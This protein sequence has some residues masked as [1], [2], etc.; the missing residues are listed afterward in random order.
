MKE[1]FTPKI[2]ILWATLTILCLLYSLMILL[3]NS[4]TF[5]FTIWLILAL[6]FY[7]CFFLSK[8]KRYKK[9]PKRIRQPFII[10]ITIGIIIFLTCQVLI[11]SHFNDNGIKDLDYIIVLG[12][13]MRD[14]GPSVIYKYRLDAAY[15]Y[16]KDN[17]DT[18]CILTGA[19]A[20]NEPVSEGEGGKEYLISKNIPKDRLIAESDSKDTV[21]NVKNAL[22]IIDKTSNTKD[23]KIG[24]VTSNFHVFRGIKI[25]QKATGHE[26]HGISAYVTPRFLPNNMVRESIGIIRDFLT[27]NL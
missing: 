17:P 3:V 13:Q 10:L 23:V 26:I 18:I 5:S 22:S 4:G 14:S 2:R 8:N 25:A 27:K 16:L 12:A 24:I 1:F 6:F 20:A 15:D 11:L 21:E 7:I 19:K 9:I